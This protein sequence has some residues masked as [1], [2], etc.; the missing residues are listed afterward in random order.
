MQ[1]GEEHI[2]KEVHRSVGDESVLS[3]RPA[4]TADLEPHRGPGPRPTVGADPIYGK[5]PLDGVFPH[6]LTWKPWGESFYMKPVDA[7]PG[8]WDN[9][10]GW[11]SELHPERYQFAAC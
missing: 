6:R 5:I 4:A 11:I 8:V 2:S 3:S 9:F 7:P 1:E 10:S